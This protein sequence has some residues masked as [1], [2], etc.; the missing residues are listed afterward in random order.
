MNATGDMN[1][2]KYIGAVVG[3]VTAT[4]L[5][6]CAQGDA[7]LH[8]TQ[9]SATSPTKEWEV[10][11]EE[12]NQMRLEVEQTDDSPGS[13][14]G[15][16]H[17]AGTGEEI[18]STSDSQTDE[19]FEVPTTGTYVVSVDPRGVTGEIILRDLN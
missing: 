16:V 3:V 14:G 18:A 15:H 19:T 1:R 4:A 2:R 17:H 8:K 12:G 5:S 6:G 11:L 7:V 10:E 13:I 9:L